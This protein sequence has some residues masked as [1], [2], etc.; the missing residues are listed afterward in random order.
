MTYTQPKHKPNPKHTLEE[1]LK[2][3]QDLI[4]N[5]LLEGTPNAAP[6]GTA[7]KSPPATP[8][9]HESAGNLNIG[10]VIES[11]K[12]LI[13]TELDVAG[14]EPP[15]TAAPAVVSA[16]TPAPEDIA[17]GTK[18]GI[19]KG[20]D[21]APAAPGDVSAKKTRAVPPG[22]LQ[23]ELPFGD[24]AAD[25]SPD[26][27]AEAN[28]E[29]SAEPELAGIDEA[30]EEIILEGLPETRESETAPPSLE[31][32]PPGDPTDLDI[33]S[34]DA[35]LD[36]TEITFELDRPPAPAPPTEASPRVHTASE[37]ATVEEIT[38]APAPEP[39]IRADDIPVLQDVALPPPE[40]TPPAPAA[41]SAP[42]TSLP[43]PEHARQVAVQVIARL[44]VELRKIGE[45]GLDPKTVDRL[46]YL[47]R[48][49]LEKTN[50][51]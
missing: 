23:Q 37:P 49:V 12:G 21:I 29:E 27:S 42:L 22:E 46:Q 16:M 43:L 11:L 3:L 19:R 39:E 1:V 44:N 25:E 4:R 10:T 15:E 35:A 32:P 28:P 13:A 26:I 18:R 48:E 34:L 7:M 33:P 47:L 30:A 40:S 51:K 20:P 8:L 9:R 6:P 24:G 14:E 50:E 17:P 45:R 41:A 2:S 36:A 31:A 5:D 38:P